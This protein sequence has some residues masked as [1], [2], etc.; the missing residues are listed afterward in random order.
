MTNLTSIIIPVYNNESTIMETLK[1][2]LTQTCKEWEI[3]IIDDGSTD[4]SP[5]I[6]QAFCV[7]EKRAKYFKRSREP[8]GGS[9]CRNLGIEISAG[10]YIIFLDADDL[11]SPDCLK[12]RTSKMIEN[13]E[14]DFAI[15]KTKMFFKLPGDSDVFAMKLYCNDPLSSFLQNKFPYP[16]QTSSAIWKRD[17]L[18]KINGFDEKFPRLQDPELHTRALI[19]TL[20][21]YK[22][23][24][25]LPP[26][27]FYRISHPKRP[28]EVS[29][30]Y[31]LGLSL[32]IQ[33]MIPLLE[34]FDKKNNTN[35]RK[36]LKLT[37]WN[38]FQGIHVSLQILPNFLSLLRIGKKMLILN[39]FEYLGLEYFF[40]LKLFAL[41]PIRLLKK[42]FTTY[43]D[44]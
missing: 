10:E 26:D 29:K 12:Q 28:I 5:S 7:T 43:Q 18:L 4:N 25:E 20:S 6:I 24:Y 1:S 23:F 17:F 9:T 19:Q 41:Q 35:Y 33:S 27:S 39:K 44:S 31:L 16:W 3:I 40:L 30:K 34:K 13:P 38:S 32:Y 2:V 37:F 15:F 8:K 36:N 14:F 11:L 22:I 21:N 42:Y